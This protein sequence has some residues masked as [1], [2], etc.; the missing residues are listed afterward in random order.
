MPHFPDKEW[1][2]E[3]A[4]PGE[5]IAGIP[6]LIC[7]LLAQRGIGGR[8]EVEKFLNP[9][10]EQLPAPTGMAGLLEAANILAQGVVEKRQVVVHGD[11][12]AD[13]ITATALL[14]LFFKE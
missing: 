6:P 1:L 3:P 7:S 11:Y 9:S 12:D 14:L 13:G 5:K 8:E 10:L 4:A 2:I